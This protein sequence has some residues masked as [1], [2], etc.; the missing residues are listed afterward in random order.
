[1]ANRYF[2][3]PYS[4]FRPCKTRWF[5]N[6]MQW[7][8]PVYFPMA[9]NIGRMEF[10]GSERIH[11]S[12]RKGN[13]VLLACNHTSGVD[14]LV[15][16]KLGQVC[17]HWFH[18]IA[19]HHLFRQSA[20]FGELLRRM[21]GYSIFRE[22][23]DLASV[24]ATIDLLH[25]GDRPVLIFPEGTYFK[26]NDRLG[27]LQEGVALI[28]RQAVRNAPRPL[29]LHPL[30]I[31]Y[32]FQKD[33]LPQ[34]RQVWAEKERKLCLPRVPGA[35]DLFRL[36]RL[37]RRGLEDLFEEP[38]FAN[39]DEPLE[40]LIFSFVGRQLASVLKS[41]P[42]EPQKDPLWQAIRKYRQGLVKVLLEAAGNPQAEADCQEELFRVMQWENILTLS[43]DYVRQ[44]PTQERIWE[45][46]ARWE[47]TL[48]DNESP[49][50]QPVTV[51]VGVGTP[52]SLGKKPAGA[53]GPWLD[54]SAADFLPQLSRALADQLTEV[55][56][57]KPVGG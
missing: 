26:Q 39:E 16:G 25:E 36:E 1:M 7:V 14:P 29:V 30:A 31:K 33:P 21:G 32:W 22:G 11:D 8:E 47:E 51:K 24:R 50:P 9:L 12:V 38:A 37:L 27:P 15:L 2:T 13:G 40:S 52:F 17:G 46:W 53:T 4:F 54:P 5:I 34:L 20:L 44:E 35:N 3:E 41:Q 28:L 49:F 19:S 18:F 57:H 42:I 55:K 48:T 56:S 10:D 45:T 43:I 23:P 6:L